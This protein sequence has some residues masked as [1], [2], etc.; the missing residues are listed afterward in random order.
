MLKPK[1]FLPPNLSVIATKAVEDELRPPVTGNQGRSLAKGQSNQSVG[2]RHN[3]AQRFNRDHNEEDPYSLSNPS[4]GKQKGKMTKESLKRTEAVRD[5]RPLLTP[6]PVGTEDDLVGVAGTKAYFDFEGRSISQRSVRDPPSNINPISPNY[7]RGSSSPAINSSTSDDSTE[8]VRLRKAYC[9]A[10]TC[11]G[12]DDHWIATYYQ[13]HVYYNH[14]RPISSAELGRWLHDQPP[15]RDQRIETLVRSFIYDQK[16]L[17][18]AFVKLFEGEGGGDGLSYDE[19]GEFSSCKRFCQVNKLSLADVA[20]WL[21]GEDDHC[22]DKSAVK[23]I[24]EGVMRGLSIRRKRHEEDVLRKENSKKSVSSG[25]YAPG[26]SPNQLFRQ[27]LLWEKTDRGIL[28]HVVTTRKWNSNQLGGDGGGVPSALSLNNIDYSCEANH[29][30]SDPNKH[31]IH[32]GSGSGCDD[33]SLGPSSLTVDDLKVSAQRNDRSRCGSRQTAA[34]SAALARTFLSNVASSQSYKVAARMSSPE[35]TFYGERMTSPPPAW[36]PVVTSQGSFGG[37]NL[38]EKV[39][40][41]KNNT[42]TETLPKLLDPHSFVTA[43]WRSRASQAAE[44]KLER[45]RVAQLRKEFAV[46]SELELRLA[47]GVSPH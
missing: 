14:T 36:P 4:S 8:D 2:S 30:T 32:H 42:P 25:F 27:R 37:S 11:C 9:H 23:A 19:E 22:R 3:H 44:E 34:G 41:N 13:S 28:E 47:G 7:R 10:R 5:R 15:P 17:A 33:P 18:A 43:G 24:F 20:S 31:F 46:G 26:E 6:T 35:N 45:S 12:V 29:N 16:H 38:T 21:D 40:Q 39:P 1:N